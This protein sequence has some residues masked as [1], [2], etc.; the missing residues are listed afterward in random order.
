MKRV[1]IIGGGFAGLAA[2]VALAEAGHKVELLERRPFLGGRAYSFLD[3]ATGDLLDNG[4]HLF[5]GCY[6]ETYRFLRKLGT[7]HLL[8]LQER[9]RVDF[10]DRENG[11]T[12]F[13]CPALPAP[14]HLLSGLL[15]L[16][17]L[18]LLDKLRT[19]NVGSV[20]RLKNGAVQSRLGHLTVD[21]WLTSC[22]QSERIK[23]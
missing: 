14:F 5:M 23:E 22:N 4:Q 19:I 17:G 18:T 2:G 15:R 10:L 12:T 3:S 1:L 9:S 20:L 16:R 11:Q 21:E 13:E 8:R 6:H 7:D